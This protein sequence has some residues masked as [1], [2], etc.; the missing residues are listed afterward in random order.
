MHPSEIC[1]AT[2]TGAGFRGAGRDAPDGEKPK[3]MKTNNKTKPLRSHRF[4][5]MKSGRKIEVGR[6][7]G[8]IAS[9]VKLLNI[10]LTQR[11]KWD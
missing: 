3:N 11:Q 4:P 7:F 6:Y 5:E 1:P 9:P 8:M 2:P 10:N